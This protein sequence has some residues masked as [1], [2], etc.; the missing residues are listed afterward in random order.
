ME[1]IINPLPPKLPTGYTYDV[2]TKIIRPSFEPVQIE[3]INILT[4]RRISICRKCELFTSQGA[5]SFCGCGMGYKVTLVYPLDENGKAFHQVN[6]LGNYTY[7][8]HL[9]K[10]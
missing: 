1:P 8:C 5:C 3:D 2:A 4:E 10:W 6:H 7:V 9:K